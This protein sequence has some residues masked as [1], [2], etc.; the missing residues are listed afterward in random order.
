MSTLLLIVFS[1]VFAIGQ[2]WVDLSKLAMQKHEADDF[3]AEELLRREA[4]RLAEMKLGFLDKQLAPLLANL[5]LSLHSEG[6]DQVADP[7]ARRAVAIAEQDGDSR[8]LGAMLNALGVV[9][10]GEGQ[11][12]RAEPVLRRSVA[13]LEEAEGADA[14]QVAQAANNL[15]TVYAD[16]H[17]YPQAEREL[18]RALPVYEKFLGAD[19]PLYAMASSN[20][21]T[22]LYQQH[23]VAEGE[24]YLRR[25][26]A[27]G[28][29]KFPASL[30]MATLRQCLAALEMSREHY[31]E[32]A[33]LLEEVIAT[34]EKLLGPDHP[35]LALTLENYA[36]AE[37]RLHHKS[38]AKNAHDRASFIRKS[39]S[40]DVK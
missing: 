30:N 12:A 21:F 22:I 7:L 25:A 17:Q 8:L 3:A 36:A 32:A 6:R 2:S 40:G 29:K 19:H 15:A 14:F 4:L 33:K 28:E 11:L 31:K 39:F 10:A 34:Q 5:A 20:M 26:L 9:L 13:F 1:A 38:Q 35:Q 37:R 16:T 18:A 24:P 27:V 23:R